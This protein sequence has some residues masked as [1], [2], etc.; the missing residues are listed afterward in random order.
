MSSNT[1][2]STSAHEVR[3]TS[4]IEE[5]RAGAAREA[6]E[7]GP[8]ECYSKSG[9]RGSSCS[10]SSSSDVKEQNVIRDLSGILFR[11]DVAYPLQNSMHGGG[12]RQR[13]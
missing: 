3:S 4:G 7:Q 1:S 9:T 2:G 6:V 11:N 10:S 8:Q 13:D 5:D 12:H